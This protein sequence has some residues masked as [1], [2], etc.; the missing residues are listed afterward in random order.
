MWEE[1]VKEANKF[2][3][4][5]HEVV[6]SLAG[7]LSPPPRVTRLHCCPSSFDK[8]LHWAEWLCASL[9]GGLRGCVGMGNGALWTLERIAPGGSTLQRTI[10]H[11]WFKPLHLEHNMPQQHPYV[12]QRI[13]LKIPK[14]IQLG[15]LWSFCFLSFIFGRVEFQIVTN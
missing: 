5:V 13:L 14:A 7:S 2:P 8:L 15:H 10:G 4:N 11:H 9:F 1:G 3:H 6:N 12:P